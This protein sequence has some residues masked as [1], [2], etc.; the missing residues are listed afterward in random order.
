MVE[1]FA[2]CGIE[3]KDRFDAIM[4][5]IGRVLE[6][7][8]AGMCLDN[9]QYRILETYYSHVGVIDEELRKV[10]EIE[11]EEHYQKKKKQAFSLYWR[12]FSNDVVIRESFVLFQEKMAG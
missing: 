4:Y 3:T 1:L 6:L 12:Y 11:S 2:E 7:M 8:K 10:L 9:D 5:H